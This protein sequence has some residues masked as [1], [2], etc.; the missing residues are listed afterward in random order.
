MRYDV[1]LNS[2]REQVPDLQTSYQAM[3]LS[4]GTRY[5][6]MVYAVEGPNFENSSI[7]IDVTTLSDGKFAELP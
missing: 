5:D 2:G 1:S 3:G 6:V 7:S 4:P